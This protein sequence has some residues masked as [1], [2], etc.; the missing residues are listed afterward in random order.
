M[1]MIEKLFTIVYNLKVGRGKLS[2]TKQKTIKN[3]GLKL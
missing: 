2:I 1:S 3:L